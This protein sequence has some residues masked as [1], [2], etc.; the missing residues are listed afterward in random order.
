MEIIVYVVPHLIGNAIAVSF[1]GFVL[2]PMYPILMNV[3]GGL[4]PPAYLAGSIGWTAGFGTTGAAL[5]PFGTGALAE[6]YGIAS[7]QP[8]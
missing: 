4:I 5:L 7:L 6:R 8:L 3:A 2:G 1:L